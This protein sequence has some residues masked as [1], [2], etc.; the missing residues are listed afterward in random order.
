MLGDIEVG[1]EC[2]IIMMFYFYM[3]ANIVI[4][5]VAVRIYSIIDEFVDAL[6]VMYDI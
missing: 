3:S 5:A 6:E 1:I 4:A 2:S